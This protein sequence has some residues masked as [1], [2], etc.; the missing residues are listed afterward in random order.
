M[1][2]TGPLYDTA[3]HSSKVLALENMTFILP[4]SAQRLSDEIANADICL[5]GPFGVSPKARR[6]IPGKIYQMMAM[7]KPIIASDSPAIKELLCHGSSAF[8][9]Q[10]GDPSSLAKAILELHRYPQL[11]STL[12]MGGYETYR[13][14]CSEAVVTQRLKDILSK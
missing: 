8:L 3:Y 12:A 10:P 1:I 6:V 14:Y 13:K 7:Q 2:G 11:C 4:I 5:G 9:C